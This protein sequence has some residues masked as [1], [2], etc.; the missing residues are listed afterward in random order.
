MRGPFEKGREVTIQQVI[1]NK[2]YSV[3]YLNCSDPVK[4]NFNINSTSS[5]LHKR[6]VGNSPLAV[7][8]S[9]V[10]FLLLFAVSFS[11][12]GHSPVGYL[13]VGHSPV[14]HLPVGHLPVGHSPVGHLPVGHS[15][16][17]HSP[18]GHSRV[19]HS[20]VGHLPVGHLPVGHSPVGHSPV[21]HS[22]VGHL[23]VGHW[24]YPAQILYIFHG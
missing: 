11:P 12:V 5:F 9:P 10:D 4:I 1:L 21:D 6:Q 23:P 22:T 14:G 18:V 7:G 8:D 20:T 17:G 16:V 19:G 3:L 24:W 2:A 15:P 13:P